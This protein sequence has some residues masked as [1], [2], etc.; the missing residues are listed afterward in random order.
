MEKDINGGGFRRIVTKYPG[1][2]IIKL[3]TV[4]NKNYLFLDIEVVVNC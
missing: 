1:I 2:K 3:N 4:E